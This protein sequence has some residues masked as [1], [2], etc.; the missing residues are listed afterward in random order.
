MGTVASTNAGLNDLMQTLTNVGSPLV[1]TLSSSSV[2]S[3]LENASPADIVQLSAAALKLQAADEMFGISS[4]SS[5]SS[6]LTA[7]DSLVSG[8]TSASSSSSDVLAAAE[9]DMQSAESAALFGA[10]G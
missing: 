10:T 3:A 7:L 1:S 4:T 6:P 8:S 5:A 2:Q 9:A